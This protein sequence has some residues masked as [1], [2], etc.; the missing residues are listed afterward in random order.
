M[1]EG[2]MNDCNL[3]SICHIKGEGGCSGSC[4]NKQ[5]NPAHV[6][7]IAACEGMIALY[8]KDDGGHLSVLKQHGQALAPSVDEF[9]AF[10]ASGMEAKRF[11]QL[12]IVGTTS[13]IAWLEAYLPEGIHKYIVAEIQYPLVAKWFKA[14]DI[15]QLTQAMQALFVV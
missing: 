14:D 5:K 2:A 9:R 1:M 11:D 4:L 7:V 10:M 3:V 6:W 13:D 8:A 15:A 12:L